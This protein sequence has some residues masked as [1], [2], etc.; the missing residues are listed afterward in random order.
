MTPHRIGWAAAI[1]AALVATGTP[2][3]TSAAAPPDPDGWTTPGP[4]LGDPSG[5]SRAAAGGSPADVSMLS[6]TP[7]TALDP[8]EDD[9][10]WLC[11]SIRV[12][13]DRADPS[14]RSIPVGFQVFPH[15]GAGEGAHDAIVVNAGGPGVAT[16]ADRSFFQFVMDPLLERRDLLLVDNRGTGTSAPLDCPGLQDGVTGRE[17][18]LAS[19]GECGQLLGEDADRYGSGDV[20]LDVEDVRR[21]LGYPKVSYYGPSYGAVDAQAYAVRF[22]ERVRAVFLDAGVPVGDRQHAYLWGLGVGPTM[23]R[24]VRLGC[25]RVR[26]CAQARPD[27]AQALPRLARSVRRDPVVGFARGLDGERRRVRVDEVML[28]AIVFG[29]THN[30]GEIPAAAAALFRDDPRPLLRLAAETFLWPGPEGDPAIF[31]FGANAAAFCN[32]Q[33]TVWRRS[34]PVPVRQAKFEEALAARPSS[35]FDPF[36]KSAITHLFPPDLCLHWPAPDR[37]T[38]AVPRGATAE[39][40]PVLQLAGDLDGNVPRQATRKIRTVFPQAEVLT[41]TGSPHTPGAWSDCARTVAQRFLRTLRTGDTDCARTPSFVAAAVAEL[42]RTASRAAQAATLRRDESGRRDR[43]V[44]TVA[45]RTV[46]DAWLRSFRIPGAV[47]DG[48]GL[49]GGRFDFDYDSFGDHA[50]VHLEEARLARDVAVSGR[51]RWTYDGNR[52]QMTI[53]V[54]GPGDHDGRLRAEGTWGFGAPF[55]AFEVTGS[56]GRRPVHLGVPAG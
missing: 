28:A 38:P 22:P 45:V 5:S 48:T 40:F 53:D 33:D 44:T 43:R 29:G 42:P 27:A 11:G 37:F 32:D 35:Q 52:L 56:L 34:D 20:A 10:A 51:S 2:V 6:T 8:C 47:A 21:A 49:R 18:F 14:G 24:M 31:S 4:G 12:P 36:S 41:V 23:Q 46:L 19:V 25:G 15:R 55:R 3:L 9:P 13:I 1:T 39:G 30:P 16:T 17:D 26:A 7:R 54:D 50:V